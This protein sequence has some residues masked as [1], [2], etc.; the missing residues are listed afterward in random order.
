MD[1][2][3]DLVCRYGSLYGPQIVL[4]ATLSAI[5]VYRREMSCN[6]CYSSPPTT[7]TTATN[8]ENLS[9]GARRSWNDLEAENLLDGVGLYCSGASILPVAM[10]LLSVLS[11]TK[12]CND[13]ESTEDLLEHAGNFLSGEPLTSAL[14][15]S[16][17]KQQSNARAILSRQSRMKTTAGTTDRHAMFAGFLPQDLQ[18]HVC[19]FL[20]PRDVTSFGSVNQACRATVEEEP[21]SLALWKALFHRDYAWTVL[22]WDIGKQAVARSAANWSDVAYSK[23]FYFRFGLAFVDYVLAGQNTA[24]RCLVG[25]RGQIYDMTPFI[26]THPGSPETV[27]VSAGKD[28]TQFFSNV[29]HSSG[30]L[31]LAKTFCVVVDPTQEDGVGY[32]PTQHTVLQSRKDCDSCIPTTVEVELMDPNAAIRPQTLFH[33]RSEF[34]QE[35]HDA[36][37]RVRL[38]R[39]A[40]RLTDVNVYYDPFRST[41]K[42]WYTNEHMEAVF[43]DDV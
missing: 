14:L 28:A 15:G 33:V 34:L 12:L 20:H 11:E 17:R 39:H 6:H 24:D 22:N 7:T 32:R 27:L 13:P 3:A 4:V 18:I 40:P 1:S 38:R 9:S 41:W 19:S 21:A 8:N 30:A 25:L 29:R 43:L 36:Q 42:A 2:A 23:E 31:R 37:R 10:H 35:R 16:P 26:L 5:T